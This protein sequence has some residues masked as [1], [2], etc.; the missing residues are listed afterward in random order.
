M[1]TMAP[2]SIWLPSTKQQLATLYRYP[3]GFWRIHTQTRPCT[4][5]LNLCGRDVEANLMK[6]SLAPGRHR[7]RPC[8]RLNNKEEAELAFELRSL[9]TQLRP[10]GN[11]ATPLITRKLA[12]FEAS[13]WLREC[14]ILA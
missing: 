14:R 2:F 9:N 6:L 5:Q 8:F 3:N 11:T 13:V 7:D 1:E 12:C 10:L 4:I